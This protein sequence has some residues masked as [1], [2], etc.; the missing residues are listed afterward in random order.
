MKLRSIT[1]I[2]SLLSV[3]ALG[4]LS[5]ATS[6]QAEIFDQKCSKCHGLHAEG[7]PIK[8]GPA[9]NDKSVGYLQM[10]I[11]DLKGELTLTG[12]TIAEHEKMD[13]SMKRLKELGYMVNP[14]KMANYIYTNFNKEA[15][16]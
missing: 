6:N 11:A 14:D 15:K 2:Y 12:S 10:E 5:A 9:L 13:H 16:K 7:N 3:C 4:S 8:K 1:I